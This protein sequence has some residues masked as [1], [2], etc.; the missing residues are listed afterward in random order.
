MKITKT[1]NDLAKLERSV[2][3]KI[4]NKYGSQIKL[5]KS[6]SGDSDNKS[7]HINF[8]VAGQVA[9]MAEQLATK[10]DLISTKSELHRAAHCLGMSLI[11]HMIKPDAY[12]FKDSPIYENLLACEE[13]DYKYQIIDDS[14]R[15]FKKIFNAFRTNIIDTKEAN[16]QVENIVDGLPNN[17]KELARS[18]ANLVFDGK[19]LSEVLYERQPGRPFVV[20]SNS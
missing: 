9:A 20:A 10:S 17:L 1:P 16:K 14:T 15:T 12:K 4:V 19:K 6:L 11:Y 5:M 7:I 18:K 8:R 13:L 2:Y 3:E